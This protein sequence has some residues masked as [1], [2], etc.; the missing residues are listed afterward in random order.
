M[1]ND[2]NMIIITVMLLMNVVIMLLIVPTNIEYKKMIREVMQE[3]IVCER[4]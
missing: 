2:I 4:T 3:Q 1:N